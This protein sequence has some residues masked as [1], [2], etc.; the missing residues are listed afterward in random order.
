MRI[1]DGWPL[2]RDG[3]ESKKTSMQYVY[4]PS[5]YFLGR[6]AV[7]WFNALCTT[8]TIDGHFPIDKLCFDNNVRD[9][10]CTS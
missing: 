1:E 4:L 9:T 10:R 6:L 8:P 2:S 7:D 3:S 5:S